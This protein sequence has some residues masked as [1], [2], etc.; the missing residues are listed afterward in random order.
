MRTPRND[1]RPGRR[2]PLHKAVGW[3]RVVFICFWALSCLFMVAAI[4]LAEE[5]PLDDWRSLVAV[6]LAALAMLPFGLFIIRRFEAVLEEG[7]GAGQTERR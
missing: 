6:S 2:F 7:R 1:E 3:F 5:P 4:A